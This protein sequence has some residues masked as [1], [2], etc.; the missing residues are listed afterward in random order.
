MTIH[1]YINYSWGKKLVLIVDL[2]NFSFILFKILISQFCED[3]FNKI[4]EF[5]IFEFIFDVYDCF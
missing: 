2:C 4:D 5:F 1:I 3:L